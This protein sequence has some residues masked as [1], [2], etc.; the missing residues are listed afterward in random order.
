MTIMLNKKHSVD[1]FQK[2]MWEARERNEEEIE[3]FGNDLEVV[4]GDLDPSFDW[5]ELEDDG[6]KLTI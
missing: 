2:A 6:E 1:D 3:E 5:F 4:L